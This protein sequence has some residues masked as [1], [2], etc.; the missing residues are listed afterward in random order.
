MLC[1]DLLQESLSLSQIIETTEKR[2]KSAPKGAL[3]VSQS[4]G[5]P[6]YRCRLDSNA[7]EIYLDKSKEKLTRKL[8]QKAYDQKVLKQAKQL[9]HDIDVLLADLKRY[10]IKDCGGA[11][12][13]EYSSC[14]P[15]LR[16][17]P[18]VE[19]TTIKQLYQNL[20]PERKA[21]VAP[22]LLSD[23]DYASN[24][25][26]TN[27]SSYNFLQEGRIFHTEKG[28]YVRSKSEAIIA[29]KLFRASIPYKYEQPL[30]LNDGQE[31]F[32]DFTVLNKRTRQEFVWEHFGLMDNPEYADKAVRKIAAYEESGLHLG[33]GL[34]ATLETSKSPL[35]LSAI[36]SIIRTQ[37]T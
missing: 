12:T 8:A 35:N 20:P 3:H 4:H 1:L 24:W 23:E 11:Q 36:E 26:N 34:I 14:H 29:D 22:C 17:R 33:V 25:E 30:T 31:V 2:L 18:D 10:G 5:S 19:L 28:D 37:L 16:L 15:A 32:P 7:K 21:L 6:Q 27:S 9:K 13:Q